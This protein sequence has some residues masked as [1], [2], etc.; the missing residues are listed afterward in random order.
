SKGEMSGGPMSY[1]EKGL[2]KN[3]K[4]MALACALFGTFAS[5]GIGSS[6]Q[7]NSVAQAVQ[8]RFGV[9]PGYTGVVLTILTA[10]VVLGG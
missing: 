2:G 7:S 3:W 1:I 5:F 10:I 4:W 8:T 6:V 9:E